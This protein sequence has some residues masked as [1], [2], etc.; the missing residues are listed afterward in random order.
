MTKVRIKT[1]NS[2]DPGKKLQLLELLSESDIYASRVI[3]ANE[4]FIIYTYDETDL[5]KLFN[6]ITDKYLEANGFTPVIPQELKA[7]RTI[8]IFN[9]DTH[10]FNNDDEEMIAEVMDKNAFTNNQITDLQRIQK[11]KIIKI[12]FTKTNLAKK[13]TETGLRMFSMS[14][15][16]HQIE[17]DTYI[18]IKCCMKC[19]KM[20][21]HFT[22][23][24]PK[25][26]GYKICSECAEEGHIW[27]ECP[28]E[29]KKCINCEGEHRTLAMKCLLRKEVIKQKRQTKK[30]NPSYS[31]VAKRNTNN[32]Q[33]TKYNEMPCISPSTH[34]LIY[35]CFVHAHIVN[36]GKPGSFQETLNKTRKANN[37]PPIIIPEDPP[38]EAILNVMAQQTRTRTIV[39]DEEEGRSE[40]AIGINTVNAS[41]SQREPETEGEEEE[42]TETEEHRTLHAEATGGMQERVMKQRRRRYQCKAEDIGLTIYTK[43]SEGWPRKEQFTRNVLIRGFESKKFKYTYTDKHT[44]EEEV[45][46]KIDNR[47]MDI[48]DRCFVL[49]DN[50]SFSKIR[51]GRV[52]EKTPPPS[53]EQRRGKNSDQNTQRIQ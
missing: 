12:T 48:S 31:N 41:Q 28:N 6:G 46:Q 14:I 53:K 49:V 34:T 39:A 47:T 43:E 9:V 23:E 15:P 2:K 19:Y 32:Q 42:E 51:S 30:E 1:R 33:T 3:V 7:K 26:Q 38:S 50:S 4:A 8:V 35:D 16:P 37:L 13:T 10:I 18:E 20:E 25:P 45:I 24:C 17:Q 40:G 22:S 44:T 52:E 29:R 27:T 5:D 11:P 21:D 36:V